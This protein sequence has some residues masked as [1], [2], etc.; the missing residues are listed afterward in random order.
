MYGHFESNAYI[1]Q[2][3][4]SL[5][6]LIQGNVYKIECY[7]FTEWELKVQS[8]RSVYII[9]VGDVIFMT[10]ESSWYRLTSGA[11]LSLISFQINVTAYHLQYGFED[12]YDLNHRVTLWLWS[13]F[14]VWHLNN[15]TSNRWLTFFSMTRYIEFFVFR[16]C[17][18]QL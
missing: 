17:C 11:S 9:N 18:C 1:S 16:L 8:K 2:H 5:L 10:S 13:S 4:V 15:V 3:F 7:F 6:F 12:G 14:V